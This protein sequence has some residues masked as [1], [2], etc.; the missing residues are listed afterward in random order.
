MTKAC[1]AIR[2]IMK[3]V[4]STRKA[5]RILGHVDR[6]GPVAVERKFKGISASLDSDLSLTPA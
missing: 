2:A 3:N 5:R 6:A 4:T 1:M